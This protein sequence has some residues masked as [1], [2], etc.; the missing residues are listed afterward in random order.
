MGDPTFEIGN[1]AESSYRD[2][3]GHETVRSL[4]L[5]T[6]LEAQPDCVQCAYNPYCGTNG[7]YNHMT[8]GSI[9]GRMRDN[10]ICALHK[11]I[12]DYLFEKLAG[13]DPEIL[14]AFERWT[15]VRPRQ[16]FVHERDAGQERGARP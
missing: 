7:A 6:N 14:R 15:T 10:G 2:V 16:H 1:V 5:A 11:G 3:V 4:A 13:A 12:Q 8:Q 9:F